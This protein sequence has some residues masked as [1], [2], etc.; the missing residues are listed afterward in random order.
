MAESGIK[1]LIEKNRFITKETYLITDNS[2]KNRLNGISLFQEY[3][4]DVKELRNSKKN[5]K[6]FNSESV[7]KYQFEIEGVLDKIIYKG[8]QNTI[9]EIGD[10]LHLMA[11]SEFTYEDEILGQ[12]NKSL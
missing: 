6:S 5:N 9:D 2:I 12:K 11:D 3:V 1:S 8:N 10:S 4:I 7:I